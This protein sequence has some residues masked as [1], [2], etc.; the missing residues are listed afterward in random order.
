MW[1]NG[2]N[3]VDAWFDKGVSEYSGVI[4]LVGGR[5]YSIVYQVDPLPPS[6][7]S[8]VTTILTSPSLPFSS[9]PL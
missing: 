6:L 1:V 8:F 3:V 9:S 7:T 5:N 2:Q 4:N